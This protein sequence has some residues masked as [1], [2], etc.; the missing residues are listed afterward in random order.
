MGDDL[1]PAQGAMVNPSPDESLDAITARLSRHRAALSSVRAGS[2]DA[3][4]EASRFPRSATMRGLVTHPG[5]GLAL[6]IAVAVIGPRRVLTWTARVLS[7]SGS[8]LR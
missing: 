5:L 2:A 4:G 8:F 7:A 1:D 6:G 3:P